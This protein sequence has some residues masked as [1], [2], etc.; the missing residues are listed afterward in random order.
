VLQ[1][2]EKKDE[3]DVFLC[4]QLQKYGNSAVRHLWIQDDEKSQ[5]ERVYAIIGF[6]QICMWALKDIRDGGKGNLRPKKQRIAHRF[7]NKKSTE[8]FTIR[9]GSQVA[10]FAC[11]HEEMHLI[12][13]SSGISEKSVKTGW[14]LPRKT[15]VVSFNGNAFCFLQLN[16]G[17]GERELL[18]KE[19]LTF[20][21]YG[22]SKS[23][24]R[25]GTNYS[26]FQLV[27]RRLA[28]CSN[29]NV[30][31]IYDLD[32]QDIIC[33]CKGHKGYILATHYDGD[34]IATLGTDRKLKLWRD[35]VCIN[36]T[37]NIPG[38]FNPGYLYKVWHNKSRI[39]YSADD[40]I[41][42]AYLKDCLV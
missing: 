10:M 42:V 17:T 25:V 2:D 9:H 26:C 38:V 16:P 14:K 20:D 28:Y 1:L 33:R 23:F 12:D 7:V 21:E 39:Y 41:Y 4:Y 11:D 24:E 40:G 6:G 27:G 36:K 22:A 19:F 18:F 5:G 3:D 29:N 8:I 30:V 15:E 32:K 34:V 31:K 13:F 35:G 37:K